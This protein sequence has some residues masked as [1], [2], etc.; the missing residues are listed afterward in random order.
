MVSSNDSSPCPPKGPRKTERLPF[1]EFKK[2]FP[3]MEGRDD[4]YVSTIHPDTSSIKLW[5][6]KFAKRIAGDVLIN[7][8]TT[9]RAVQERTGRFRLMRTVVCWIFTSANPAL[10]SAWIFLTALTAIA[11][12]QGT[13]RSNQRG[14]GQAA[15]NSRSRRHSARA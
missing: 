8:P 6:L 7:M 5:S 1:S 12:G 2:S 9:M 4:N 15:S 3:Q 11:N 13:L 10:L 14:D